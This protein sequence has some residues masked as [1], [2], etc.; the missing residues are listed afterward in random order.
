MDL[1][2]FG[3]AGTPLIA[4]PSSLGRFYE[5]EDFGMI[6]A[7]SDKIEA[8]HNMV[9]CVDS[10]DSES[11]YNRGVHPRVRLARH[12]QYQNYIF[13]EVL[14]LAR[15]RASTD[16]VMAAGASFGAYHAANVVFRR[17]REFGKLIALSGAFDIKAFM[18][19][20]YDQGVYFNNPVDFVPNITDEG[21]LGALRDTDIVMTMG[22]YDPCREANYR[23][24]HVLNAKG[25][26]HHLDVLHGAFGHDWPW[27]T[28]LIQ[29]YIA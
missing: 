21:T 20:H 29:K 13:D 3:H 22:E 27:W 16:F 17:P 28:S 8:G 4:F 9:V 26:P 19:G 25:I 7:L 5:W 6:T 2:I 24:H 1:L 15:H 12:E 18:D 11:L 23:M 10:V 14:P